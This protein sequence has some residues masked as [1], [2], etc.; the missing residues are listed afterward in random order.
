[1]V[2]NKHALHTS[3]KKREWL[4]CLLLL[5]ITKN[6]VASMLVGEGVSYTRL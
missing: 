3:S 1:M 6:V 4:E 2:T 5:I